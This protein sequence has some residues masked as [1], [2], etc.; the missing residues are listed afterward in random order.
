MRVRKAG[1]LRRGEIL[2]IAENLFIQKGY[3]NTT[4]NDLL[5]A[6]GLA[7]G[8]L[9]YYYSSKEDVLDGVVQRHGAQVVEVATQI[10][11]AEGPNAPEKLMRLILSLKPPTEHDR[12]LIDDLEVSSDGYMF[13]KSLTDVIQRLAPVLARIVEQGVAEEVFSTNYPLENAEIIL[14]A[15]HTLFDNPTIHWTPAETSQRI[16]ALILASERIIGAE[17]GSFLQLAAQLS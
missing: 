12:Q 9:Y 6:T 10:A 16:T 1:S 14:S 15:V 2:D 11:E 17:E 3:A 13:L 7:K 8:S 4:I 5:D